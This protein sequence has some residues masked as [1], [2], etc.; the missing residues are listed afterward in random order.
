MAGKS[1]HHHHNYMHTHSTR[2]SNV[3][4]AEEIESTFSY[5]PP[6]AW[7]KTSNDFLNDP[8]DFSFD[9]LEKEFAKFE[10]QLMD[11]PLPDGTSGVLGPASG[12]EPGQARP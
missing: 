10:K 12:H 5:A 2:G 8:K 1:T 3:E 7:S 11:H 9:E 6:L 4:L